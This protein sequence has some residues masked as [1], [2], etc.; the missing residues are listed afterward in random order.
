MISI[1]IPT[2][3]EEQALA[4]CLESVAWSD[5]VY[6]YDSGST[7]STAAIAN[8]AGVHFVQRPSGDGQE[9]FGGN[10]SEHKNWALANLPFKYP[11]VLHLDADERVTPE[12]VESMR[13]AV[14]NPGDNV[15]FRLRRRDF[16]S[17]TWLK[18]VQ[19]SPYYIRL[20]RPEQLHY[21][22]LINPISVPHGPIG[23]L[24]GLLDHY[25]FSKG[26]THWLERHN[27]Y[28]SLE[29]RQL[30]NNRSVNR[31]FSLVQAFFGKDRNQRRF[32]QKEMF[33][34]M[35]ARP[36]LKFLLLYVG[37]RG[38]LDGRAGFRYAVLQSFYEYMIVLKTK[39]LARRTLSPVSQTQSTV[40]PD[41]PG[42]DNLHA[43]SR[44]ND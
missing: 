26:I 44:I 8:C 4:G 14:C 33:Y 5:D 17:D 2:K 36:V 11:W 10:E 38:F 32:H 34:R 9:L 28:S 16:W 39:E 18:H 22:R 31:D 27:R 1:L 35:P 43:Q 20:F 3:N 24:A 21:E 37:K 19:L 15:A 29:A 13:Y 23:E 41:S 6:V 7:D 25:P 40:T 42:L 12:L 30:A